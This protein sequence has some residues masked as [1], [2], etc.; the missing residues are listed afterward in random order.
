MVK[1]KPLPYDYEDLE[2]A[3]G[4]EAL[5][6]HHQKH[7]KGYVDKLNDALKPYPQL[8]ERVGGLEALLGTPKYIPLDIKTKV[9]NFGGGVY[10][11]D[12]FW[13][14]LSPTNTE[15]FFEGAFKRE[16]EATFGG[17]YSLKKEIVEKGIAH[18]G[19]GWV[20]L[21]VTKDGLKVQTL[22]NQLTPLMRGHYPLLCVDLWEHAYYL[23]F[24]SDRA[25]F[26]KS[27]ISNINWGNVQKRY[28]GF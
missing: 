21:V 19:S 28:M 25:T 26:L 18:F 27:L 14:S 1:L 20:W 6:E 13:Q 4:K 2:P 16:V 22:D 23:D 11:H 17:L 15:P 24:K 3:I 7:H 10:T 12:L 5:I 8:L 9:V